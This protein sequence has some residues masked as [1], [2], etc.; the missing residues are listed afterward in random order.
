LRKQAKYI[1]ELREQL[2]LTNT[3]VRKWVKWN[4]DSCEYEAFFH[5]RQ[6]VV[7]VPD[8]EWSFLVGLHEIGH[9]STGPRLFT[10]LS[11]YNAEKWAIRRAKE[12]YGIVNEE[13]IQDAKNYVC[14]HLV[15]DL[16]QSYLSLDNVKPYVLDWIGLSKEEVLEQ[17]REAVA[18]FKI[19]PK[20]LSK[21]LQNVL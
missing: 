2:K 17:V 19:D 14:N 12:Q 11:E 4:P 5:T 3:R 1:I 6:V 13:Y 8:C 16:L 7:P 18:T 15:N 9:I 21:Y 20:S 10:Y